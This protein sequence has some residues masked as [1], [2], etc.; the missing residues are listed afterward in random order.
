MHGTTR[1]RILSGAAGLACTIAAANAWPQN[2]RPAAGSA[3]GLTVTQIVDSS[4]GQQDVSR[5]F[6]V[7][8]R[9]AW[10]DINARGGVRGRAVHHQVLEVDASP[11]SLRAALDSVRDHPGCVALSGSAGDLVATQIV[12]QL[13][14]DRLGLA[15]AAPWL[16][17]SSL[18]PDAQ[19]FPIF[20]GRQEQMAH[21]LKSLTVMGVQ[22]LG[23]IYAS[24]REQSMFRDDVERIAASL[25]LKVV[26][27]RPTSDLRQLGQQL[28]AGT[29]A[30]LLFTGGT[31]ELVQFTQG[32]AKQSRQRYVIALADVNLQTMLQM[33]AARHTAVIATQPVPMVTASLP[34]VRAYRET[35]L[36]LFDEPPTPLSLAGFLAARYTHDVLSEVDGV[37][38]RQSALA[39]FQRRAPADL[40]GFWVESGPQRR[41][42]AYVT[43][44]M[45][46][47]DG[48]VIG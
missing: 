2:G 3:R 23:A 22:T 34:V 39:A 9:A 13:R 29:P 25:K 42:G 16:Q 33:G 28:D 6:L 44:T 45:L 4:P 37:L 7:G 36:R 31:P 1:R 38:T 18:E 10:Q 15:H 27:F 26:P 47:A 20:A 41:A 14:R 40:R 12:A 32:L 30:I 8:A 17:N 48:R 11:A 21:A 19:T 43:Q 24:E 35:L 46:T 5:D